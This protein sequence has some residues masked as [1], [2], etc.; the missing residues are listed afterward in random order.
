[1][2]GPLLSTSDVFLGWPLAPALLVLVTLAHTRG[3]DHHA[4]RGIVSSRFVESLILLSFLSLD[5]A[6]GILFLCDRNKIYS[7]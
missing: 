5:H 3:Q 6:E 4:V 7:Y 2:L 1:M